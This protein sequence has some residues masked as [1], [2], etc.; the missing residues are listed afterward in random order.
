VA[1]QRGPIV[2]CM[3]HLD[4]PDHGVGM[5]LAGYT[6]SLDGATDAHF[7]PNLLDGVMVLTHPGTISK[8]ATDMALYF[9]ASTPKAPESPTTVK[10]IPYYAWANR[11]SASMQVWIP[12][13][14]V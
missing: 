14:D 4:Q 6:V 11:E 9:P 8:S 10:L 1:F 5:N 2:F 13:K 12:Y 7:E 3:E